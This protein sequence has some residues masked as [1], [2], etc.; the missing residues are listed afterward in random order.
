[1]Q[2]SLYERV[3]G[4]ISKYHGRFHDDKTEFVSGL[5][6]GAASG[7]L[8][9]G[10]GNALSTGAKVVMGS[11]KNSG[12]MDKIAEG[13]KKE[14]HATGKNALKSGE[15][16]AVTLNQEF[17]PEKGNKI[18]SKLNTQGYVR[19]EELNYRECSMLGGLEL[20]AED[21]A[22]SHDRIV[23]CCKKV[24]DLLLKPRD[25]GT[26]TKNFAAM[27]G[28]GIA[29]IQMNEIVSPI[30]GFAAGQ[31]G[32]EAGP[33]IGNFISDK[34]NEARSS[35][36]ENRQKFNGFEKEQEIVSRSGLNQKLG[37]GQGS[38]Q[39]EVPS[40]ENV[41]IAGNGEAKGAQT[42][43]NDF[44]KKIEELGIFGAENAESVSRTMYVE[45]NGKKYVVFAEG[46]RVYGEDGNTVIKEDIHLDAIEMKPDGGTTYKTDSNPPSTGQDLERY[47]IV[48]VYL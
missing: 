38:G 48:S 41:I 34:V 24:A 2:D 16:M 14:L 21:L 19:F 22:H 44:I 11:L 36:S 13:I 9:L 28:R 18:Y 1:M 45:S 3:G 40:G 6:A 47:I 17:G 15:L 4:V 7:V 26:L 23:H 20:I 46:T 27:V 37:I 29:S 25:Y 12:A 43:Y 33:L 30:T 10:F 31:V 8:P 32:A 39:G 42:E 35:G 5:S